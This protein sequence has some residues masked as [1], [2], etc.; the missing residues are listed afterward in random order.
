MDRRRFLASSSL[1]ALAATATAQTKAAPGKASP[2]NAADLMDVT[3]VPGYAMVGQLDGKPLAEFAG[4]RSTQPELSKRERINAETYFPAASFSKVVFYWGVRDLARKGK[5]A[6]NRPLQ[7]YLPLGLQGDAAKITALHVVSHS[8]GLVNWRFNAQ[9]NQPLASSFV[10]GTQFGY[11]GEGFFLLQRVVEHL[12]GGSVASYLKKDILPGLGITTGSLAWSPSLMAN[13]AQGHTRQ[14]EVMERSAVFYESSTHDVIK[15]AGLD[16]EKAI[17]AE[18]T[19]AF[20]KANRP[21]LPVMLAPNVAGSMWLRP[22]EFGVFLS[23]VLEDATKNPAEYAALTRMNDKMSWG[24]GW[25]VDLTNPGQFLWSYGDTSGFKSFALVS[26]TRRT[27]VAVFTN[28][29]RG[30][31]LYG[32]ILRQRLGLDLAALYWV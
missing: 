14:G 30:T 24:H 31:S 19:D 32:G 17:I 18:V 2:L 23:K 27:A 16:P 7:D 29:E 25:A 15:N 13:G 4:V 10:P 3:R 21:V 28:G 6:W 8:T 12:V 11:S 9:A 22:A 1:A 5:L 20:K 26:P